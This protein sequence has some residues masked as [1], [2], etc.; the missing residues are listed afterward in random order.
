VKLTCR[1][2]DQLLPHQCLDQP[3]QKIKLFSMAQPAIGF[4]P[5]GE[6]L[7]CLGP[8]GCVLVTCRYTMANHILPCKSLSLDSSWHILSP[9]PTMTQ[10]RHCHLF[11]I[12]DIFVFA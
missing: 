1:C 8:N 7:A 4:I 11:S 10:L 12:L 2:T 9:L 6:E 3:W 5:K